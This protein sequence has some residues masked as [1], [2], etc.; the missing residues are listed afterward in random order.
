M[1]GGEGG[2]G[3]SAVSES[4][5][6]LALPRFMRGKKENQNFIF[7][8][9][10]ILHT[11][12]VFLGF[13]HRKNCA[14]RETSFTSA[15]PSIITYIIIVTSFTYTTRSHSSR[16]G[17]RRQQQQRCTDT[18]LEHK[19]KRHTIKDRHTHTHK[20]IHIKTK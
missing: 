4:E 1:K 19:Q 16:E 13:F 8:I 12:E 11:K 20:Y 15:M 14:R 6:T 9:I 3:E 7:S 10:N 18:A 17:K 2:D 5:T